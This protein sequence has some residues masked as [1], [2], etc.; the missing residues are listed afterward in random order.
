MIGIEFI[1][2]FVSLFCNGGRGTFCCGIAADFTDTCGRVFGGKGCDCRLVD[3]VCIP[4]FCDCV[5]VFTCCV[6]GGL[7]PVN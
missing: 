1:L 4:P 6:D 3:L 5:A 2:G 7:E